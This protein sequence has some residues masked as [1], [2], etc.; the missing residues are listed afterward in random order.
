MSKVSI[1]DLSVGECCSRYEDE[2][3][4]EI[5]VQGEPCE[6]SAFQAGR[7]VNTKALKIACA[8]GEKK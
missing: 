6:R 7:N 3:Y 4:W 2:L 5:W 1:L 8:W